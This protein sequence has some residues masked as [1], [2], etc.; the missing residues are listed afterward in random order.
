[1]RRSPTEGTERGIHTGSGAHGKP[2]WR[3]WKEQRDISPDSSAN[4]LIVC[5]TVPD[6]SSGALAY[7]LQMTSLSWAHR[8]LPD[9]IRR[10]RHLRLL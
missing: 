6:W 10:K 9:Q 8:Q 7:G 3:H 5:E 2:H 1:M 4:L